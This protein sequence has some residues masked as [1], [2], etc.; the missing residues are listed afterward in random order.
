MV[1]FRIRS[2]I[3]GYGVFDLLSR[4]YV[5]GTHTE[6]LGYVFLVIENNSDAISSGTFD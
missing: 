4:S 2:C 3:S 5:N 1:T 6:K